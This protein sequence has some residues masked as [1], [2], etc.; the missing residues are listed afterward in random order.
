MKRGLATKRWRRATN[1]FLEMTRISDADREESSR[2]LLGIDPSIA[3]LAKIL[4]ARARMPINFEGVLPRARG[5]F[6]EHN[7]VFQSLP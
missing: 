3:E 5:N 7:K 2:F 1:N 4:R 6:E